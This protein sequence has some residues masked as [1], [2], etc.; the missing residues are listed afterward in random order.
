MAEK[1]N[2]KVCEAKELYFPVWIDK[3]PDETNSE[4]DYRVRGEIEGSEWSLNYC[5]SKYELIPCSEIF[6]NIEK[7][8]TENKIGYDVTYRQ[9]NH[10]R[11][12]AD[13][14]LTDKDLGYRLTGTNDTIQPMLRVQHSYNGMTKYRINFGY[15][16]LVCTNGLVVP[17]EEMKEYCLSIVGKHTTEIV[18]SF[19]KLDKMLNTFIGNKDQIV[20]AITGKYEILGG[21]WVE[22]PIERLKEVLGATKISMVE[23]SKFNTL[24][25]IMGRIRKESDSLTLGYNGRVND[26]LIYNGI[27]QYLN[28]DSR[29]ASAPETRIDKDGNVLEYMLKT[30]PKE[31]VLS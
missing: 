2:A 3:N 25:D 15:F 12:Y 5:S 29:Y 21:V 22:N 17:V 24:E 4:Y 31:L 7:V 27:N 6:P 26:W 20:A 11:F 10:V 13:Y 23:N 28:D 16:R 9:L 1:N 19:D 8:L 18:K 14:L 30:V